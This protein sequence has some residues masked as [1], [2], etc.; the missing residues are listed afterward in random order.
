LPK[1]FSVP[2]GMKDI[3]P[4][5]MEKRLWVQTRILEVLQRY[6]FKIIEPTPME[7]L[8]TLEAKSGSQIKD[9]IYWFADK[10]GRNLGLRFDLTVGMARIV[11]NRYDLPEPLKLCA[12]ADA[13]RYDEPQF[14][15]YRHFWQWDA[16][17]FGSA[18]PLADA[19]A[20]CVGMDVLDSVGLKEYEVRISNRKLVESYLAKIGVRDRA[21]IDGALIAIDKLSKLSEDKVRVEFEKSGLSGEQIDAINGLCSIK[22]P[23]ETVLSELSGVIRGDPSLETGRSELV[24]LSDI[25][26]AF[27]RK[28]RCVYDLS[29]VRG[30]GYYDGVVFE[31]YDKGGED[32]GSIFGGGRYDKLCS[33]Y[34]KQDKPATGLAGGIERLMLSLERSSLYPKFPDTPK[35]FVASATKD[36]IPKIWE[37]VEK[38]R[39]DGIATDFDLKEKSLDKQLEYAHSMRIP[40]VIIIGRR[41][42]DKGLVRLRDM[43][44]RQEKEV[45]ASDIQKEL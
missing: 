28:S 15:R 11:A 3:E 36:V 5:E 7:H 9:E 18:D 2:R 6:G 32:I 4:Q 29:I 14:G 33:I 35:V 42:L 44:S 40:Y 12:I 41:E 25:L 26:G 20:I 24:K 1:E 27:G 17:I 8:E 30:I 10:A 45:R 19:E 38:L 16:E 23:F 22:G 37:T 31:A 39:R 21:Q 34:G 43:Q 13:W